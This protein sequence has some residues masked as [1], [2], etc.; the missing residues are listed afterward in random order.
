MALPF[1]GLGL[2]EGWFLLGLGLVVE[3]RFTEFLKFCVQVKR[4]RCVLVYEKILVLAL[5]IV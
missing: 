1:I 2:P 5:G 4:Y 3:D